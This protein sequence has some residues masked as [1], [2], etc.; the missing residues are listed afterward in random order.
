[1]M[2]K[3]SNEEYVSL[4]EGYKVFTKAVGEGDVK[5]LTIHGGPGLTHECYANFPEH[6]NPEGVQ[7][8]FYDQLG[9]FYSDQPED[10]ALWKM[11][12]FV[13]ELHQVV[14]AR[15][16][17]NQ[18]VF[19]NSWGAMVLIDYLLKYK[20]SFKG[21]VLSGMP[22][23][24]QKFKE[25]INALR[26]ALPENEQRQLEQHEKDGNTAN[27]EYQQLLFTYWFN[28]HYSMLQ[29]WPEPL[30]Q[31][32][33][34]LS[35]QVLVSL[36]GGNVFNFD[37]PATVWDRSQELHKIS[38]PTLLLGGKND[39]VFEED[40]KWMAESMP[41]ARYFVSPTGGHFCWWDDENEVFEQIKRFTLEHK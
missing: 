13:D 28:R 30:M 29:P 11:E 34:H 41:N 2:H 12:R 23:R 21:I 24:F 6:L 32:L 40:L 26:A 15:Q 19:A 27:P 7:V 20:T 33:Q 10:S 37:G 5:L 39:L 18:F 1:M 25:N 3:T 35:P 31:M 4:S 22:A 8:V 9:S 17:Q 14:Q 16:L 38:T 36:F